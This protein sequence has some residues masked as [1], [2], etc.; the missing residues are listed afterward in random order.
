MT[1]CRGNGNFNRLGFANTNR[2]RGFGLHWNDKFGPT[3]RTHAALPRQ[4]FLDVKLMT[5]RAIKTNTHQSPTYVGRSFTYYKLS[6]RSKKRA[7]T[8][9]IVAT[10]AW[11]RDTVP[12]EFLDFTYSDSHP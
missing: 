11:R 2:L 8:L 5:V 4:E 10:D 12:P 3:L 9:C 1:R 6:P 7:R